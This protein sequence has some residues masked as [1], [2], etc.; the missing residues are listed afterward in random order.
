MLPVALFAI[1]RAWKP[2]KHAMSDKWIKKQAHIHTKGYYSVI[3]KGMK[4]DHL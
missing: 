3:K 2:P 4:L 1:A